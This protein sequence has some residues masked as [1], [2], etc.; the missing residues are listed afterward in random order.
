MARHDPRRLDASAYPW[1]VE[2]ETRFGDMD[3]NIHLNNVAIAG[4][5]EEARVRFNWHIRHNYSVGRPR[6]VVARLEIDY[7]DEG[8][9]RVPTA[10]GVAVVATGSSS[11]R[12]AMGLF[13]PDGCIGLSDTV[14][15][16]RGDGG[17]S[18]IPDPLR[19]ALGEFALR[20]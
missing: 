2:L 13:Q 10:I 18:P 5:Y 15:V 14:M 20:P 4:L 9:Y 7:L 11:W 12:V 3:V 16:H 8:K 19:T 6:F 1:S 17:P